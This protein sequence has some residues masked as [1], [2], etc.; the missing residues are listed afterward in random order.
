MIQKL[1]AVV[2]LTT[3]LF[4]EKINLNNASFSQLELIG[5]TS[6]EISNILEYRDRVGYFE[7][8]YD[9]LAVGMEINRIHEI[10]ND[11]STDLPT[12]S[13]FEKDIQ[14]A[15]YKLGQW[16]SNEGNSEGLSEIWL[17][18]FFEPQN[19]NE[20]NYDDLMALPN[21][22]PVDAVA[23]LKQKK[24]GYING[25]WELK[26]SP[27]ISRWGYK[28][29][30]DFIRFNDDSVDENATHIRIN[31][32]VRTVPITSNPDEDGTIGEFKNT[33]IPEQFY[34]ISITNGQHYKAGF[35]YHRYMGQPDNIYT[36]KGFLQVEKFSLMGLKIDRAVLGNF[37]ASY[38]QGVVFESSD[39]F[40]P[41]RTGFGFSKRTEGI[42]ADMTRSC[43]YV[44]EGGAVQLSN[45][46]FRASIFASLHPRDAIINEDGSFT[47]LIIMQP[48]LPFGVDDSSTIYHSLISSVNEMTWGG[49]FQ[50]TPVIGTQF[51]LTFYESLYDREH[52]PQIE[53]TITGGE[54][55][56]SGDDFYLKYITNS[57]DAE[58]AAMDTSEAESPIWDDAKSFVRFSGINF[59]SVFS[60]VSLQGE[61]GVMLKDKPEDENPD[62]LVL[63][64]FAQFSNF[65][66]I[67]LY[68]NYDLNYDNPYQRSYSNYQRFKTSIFE[69]AYWLEDPIYSFLYTANPQPQ[70]EEGFFISSRYQFHRSMVGTLNWD[71][72][73]RKAD[74][75]KYYRTVASI[76]WRPVFNFRIK[77][78][79]K[80]QA[81][82]AFD[83]QHPSPFYSRETRIQAR[84]RMSRYNQF[85][86]LYS[87][88]YTTF[89]PRPRL[90]D[91]AIG[92]EM[93]VGDIGSPDESMGISFTHHA[94]Q[95]FSIKGGVLYI[96]GFLWYFQDT[97]FR[98][99]NSESGAVHTWAS[100]DL[101]PTS[102]FR[103]MLK[104]SHTADSFSTRVVDAQAPDGTWVRNPQ[105]TQEDLD[106][107]IQV[108]YAL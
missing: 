17:D 99:F 38:G 11:V 39:N 46:N 107:R 98:I 70:A 47:S 88:G 68:R 77:V 79:Q 9:L 66:L 97:D 6:S 90:T 48:R 15:S 50:I 45:D 61:Y 42:H 25:T 75:A 57:T 102:L 74:N 76:D 67:A 96:K 71:T 85:E 7:T 65:N 84:L 95:H 3:F 80:W 72:W 55:D 19:V 20:M 93:M 30:V 62:A 52:I 108:N 69:D 63:S 81:R 92:G 89:S 32:L 37:T 34:K 106:F 44:M 21:L 23:V 64:A 22:S 14:R 91:S 83:I 53:A 54:D 16:I 1:L 29:L 2:A 100:V 41:R 18:K 40:S 35:S 4:S 49:N 103:I 101:K 26:N 56:Y 58:I 27:G 73:N 28:N 78:R 36:A 94:D 51:G 86:I 82:G 31:S 10:R 59:T 33:S 12:L 8:I 105:V 5:F 24:R 87:N 104:V 60:N 43:Q 13:T